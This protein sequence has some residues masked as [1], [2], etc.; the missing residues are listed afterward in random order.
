MRQSR[1]DDGDVDPGV[2]DVDI[3]IDD[4]I[5]RLVV[6]NISPR[7]TL[8]IAKALVKSHIISVHFRFLSQR[9]KIAITPI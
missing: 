8:A 1:N 6:F 4:V 3:D 2:V 5:L 9:R 7:V